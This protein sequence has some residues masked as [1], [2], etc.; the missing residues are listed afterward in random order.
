VKV[1]TA[2]NTA[3]SATGPIGFVGAGV[4]R[5]HTR[6]AALSFAAIAVVCTFGA[7]LVATT[8]TTNTAGAAE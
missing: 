6:S 7:I 4:L 5:Q 8:T 2:V 1:M 3:L